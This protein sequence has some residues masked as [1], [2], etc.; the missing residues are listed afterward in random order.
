MRHTI[1]NSSIMRNNHENIVS[2]VQ[3]LQLPNRP[4][5]QRYIPPKAQVKQRVRGFAPAAPLQVV[6][7]RAG[8]EG[9]VASRLYR[10][11]A[12]AVGDGEVLRGAEDAGGVADVAAEENEGV[13]VLGRAR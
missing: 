3:L 6:E 13:G 2:A 5:R 4:P 8:A 7:S 1:P 12:N 9:E 10:I 11:G